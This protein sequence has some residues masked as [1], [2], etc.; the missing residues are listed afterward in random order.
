MS[1]S[2]NTG[3]FFEQYSPSLCGATAGPEAIFRYVA[4]QSGTL[5]VSTSS[6]GFEKVLYYGDGVCGMPIACAKSQGFGAANI[7]IN[8]VSGETYW[9]GFDSPDIAEWGS[10]TLTLTY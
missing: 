4:P 6:G 7:D 10:A 3:S 2:I 9:I 5:H 8:T 1:I